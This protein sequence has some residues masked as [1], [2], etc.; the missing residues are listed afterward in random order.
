MIRIK[1]KFIERVWRQ[2]CVGS[3]FQKNNKIKDIKTKAI[4]IKPEILVNGSDFE[5]FCIVKLR[6]KF[7]FYE[8]PNNRNLRIASVSST[9]GWA[10][11]R[12]LLWNT[13]W[14]FIS[15]SPSALCQKI[16]YEIF[17][18]TPHKKFIVIC[19]WTFMIHKKFQ[20]MLEDIKHALIKKI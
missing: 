14:I 17:T 13:K 2:K 18:Q 3:L 5:N 11:Y 16:L 20:A 15:Y 8:N 9:K 6:R 7:F 4:S 10:L 1:W 12:L 19:K